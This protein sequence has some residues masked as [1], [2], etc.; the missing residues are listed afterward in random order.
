[1]NQWNGR[2]LKL[3]LHTHCL[4]ALRTKPTVDAVRQIV[5]AVKAKG[6][7]GLAITEHWNKDYGFRAKEILEEHFPGEIVLIPGQEI[8]T[9]DHGSVVELYLEGGKMFRFIAHPYLRFSVKDYQGIHGIEIDNGMHNYHID[10]EL[11]GEVAAQQDLLLLRN[12]DAH[13]LEDLGLFC[14]VMALEDLA[15]RAAASSPTDG[16]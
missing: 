14:N 5:K 4:E 10:K 13:Y 2:K 6:L 9:R 11:V 8:I 1:M 7:D 15:A 3:D 12:S 16:Q